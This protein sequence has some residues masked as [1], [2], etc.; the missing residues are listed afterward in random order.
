[1]NLEYLNNRIELSRIPITAIAEGLGIS[2]QSVYNKMKGERD[3]TTN[4]VTKLCE[5]LRLTDQEKR[6][7]FFGNKVD[8]NDT[9]R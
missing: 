6:I 8:K 2:R 5:L 4:E 9:K 7:I 1:L 3:F